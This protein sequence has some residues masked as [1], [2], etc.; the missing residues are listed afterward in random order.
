[1]ST[2]LIE[3]DDQIQVEVFVPENEMRTASG[4]VTARV[5]ETMDQIEPVLMRACKPLAN[6]WQ[7]LNKEMSVK[8]ANVA[9]Q[10]GFSASGNVFVA[11]GSVNAN[12]TVSLKMTPKTD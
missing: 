1:M 5:N 11:K 9:I 6:V 12:L 10:L 3:L 7:E 8:E 4:S 2:K